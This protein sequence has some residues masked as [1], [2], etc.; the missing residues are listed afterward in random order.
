MSAG[1]GVAEI[2]ERDGYAVIPDVV[3]ENLIKELIVLLRDFN[4]VGSIRRHGRVYAIRNLLHEI[5][6][7]GELAESPAIRGLAEQVLGPNCLAVKATFFDKRPEANWKVPWHQDLT[8]AVE[9]RVDVEGFGT[10]TKKAG[11]LHV[12]PPIAVLEK[13]LAIRVHLGD[14]DDTSGALRVIPGSHA[15]GLAKDSAIRMKGARG[16]TCAVAKGGV[17]VLRPLLLHASSAAV[18]PAHRRVIHFEFAACELPGGLRWH[19]ESRRTNPV[20]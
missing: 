19:R 20:H 7:V 8:I 4:T 15:Q 17:V 9:E 11:V 3:P 12:Q 16:V 1:Q 18:K 14:C 5:S 6:A 2:V 10:W 13:M